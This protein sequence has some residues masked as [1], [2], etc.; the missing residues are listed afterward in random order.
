MTTL[1]FDISLL[2]MFLPLLAGARVVIADNEE[3]K[4]GR[5]LANLIS[6]EDISVMQATPATWQMLLD[7]GWEGNSGL[8]IFCGGE[9]LNRG[10]A[11]TLVNSADELWNLYGPTETTVWSTFEMIEE[12]EAAISIGQ[13]IGNTQIYILDDQHH[14]VPQGFTG[15]LWI[16]GKGLARG[17]RNRDNLTAEVFREIELP[18]V[19]KKRI[20][21]TG[22]LG[23]WNRDGKLE[24]LGRIDFQ[25]KIR[26]V[27]MELGD[28]ETQLESFDGIKQ[29]VVTKRTDLPTGE[30]LVGYYLAEGGSIRA[31]EIRSTLAN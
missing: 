1:S 9:A 8:R 15:E 10:L 5:R 21:R 19:G 24:C 20:Y 27:R 31:A 13:P 26:G 18:E 22:D 7:S 2:E 23:R 29:A 17:Y 25:V 3:V 14:P 4:D 11:N 16:G 30:G 6:E 28:I 12:S